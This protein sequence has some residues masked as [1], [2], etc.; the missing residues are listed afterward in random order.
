M[1]FEENEI[2]RELRSLTRKFALKELAPLVDEDER[3]EIFRPELIRKL[4]EL[5]LTGIPVPEEYGGAG[6]GYCE[7]IAAIEELAAVNLGYAISVAVTGLPQIIL[8]LFGSEEQKKKFI[9]ALAWA[10]E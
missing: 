10:V 3:N 9:P 1:N 8:S 5:G 2:A 6:L 7:Y 4:G